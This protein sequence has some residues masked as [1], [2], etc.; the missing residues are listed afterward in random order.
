MIRPDTTKWNQTPDDLRRLATES[1]HP[2]TR[3]RFLALYQI[4]TRQTNA[5]QWAEQIDRCDECVMGWIQDYNERGPKAMTYRRTGGGG[6]FYTGSDEADHRDGL[7]GTQD[8]R[9]ARKRLD[10]EEIAAVGQQKSPAR[11][12]PLDA[13]KDVA[14]RAVD[15]E[16]V[17]EVPRQTQS[18][19]AG[20]VHG[21]VSERVRS[22]ASRGDRPDLRR[23]I[24]L[25]PRP[26]D[27]LLLESD[28]RADL[29]KERLPAVVR[30]HQLVRSVQFYGRRMLHLGRGGLAT[31][32]APRNSCIGLTNG[33]GRRAVGSS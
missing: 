18:A 19:K 31:R 24:A 3:E 5:T 6:P 20:G 11:G 2:R 12:V 25:S 17:Q 1:A 23:R 10:A 4:A 9:P 13:S 21:T 8:A 15:L 29:A 28:R 7:H 32:R 30:T 16:E 33:F 22:G 14:G 27:R 26:G